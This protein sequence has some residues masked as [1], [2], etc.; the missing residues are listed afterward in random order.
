M[1]KFWFLGGLLVAPFI[2]GWIANLVWQ[3]PILLVS[4]FVYIFLFLCLTPSGDFL[5]ASANYETKKINPN[6]SV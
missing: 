6:H 5:S 1:K 3:F 2:V 4:G